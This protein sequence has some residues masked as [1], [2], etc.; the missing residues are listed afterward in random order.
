M[1]LPTI[2]VDEDLVIGVGRGHGDDARVGL[3]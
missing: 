1:W 2:G 3:G